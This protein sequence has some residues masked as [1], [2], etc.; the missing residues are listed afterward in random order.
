M[1]IWKEQ[2]SPRSD[3]TPGP[4]DAEGRRDGDRPAGSSLPHDVPRRSA[5]REG[6]ESVLAAGLTIEGKVEGAGNVRLAGHFKGDVNV[7][8]NLTIERGAKVTGAVRANTVIIAGELE[9][10]VDAAAR[11]ELVDSGVVN[12]DIKAGSLTVAAGSRMRGQVT[13]GMDEAPPQ[14]AARQPEPR[15]RVETAAAS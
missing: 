13:F 11:V 6:A 8:G 10:N 2:V 9:G 15:M 14:G 5:E 1:A 4:Q 3:A 12:G 7:N